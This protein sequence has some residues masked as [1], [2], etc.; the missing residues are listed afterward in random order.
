MAHFWKKDRG[1]IDVYAWDM[2]ASAHHGPVCTKCGL[3]FCIDC[4]PEFLNTDC[5]H[6][7]REK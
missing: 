6:F 4:N 1:E 3:T 5:S 2:Y 7:S